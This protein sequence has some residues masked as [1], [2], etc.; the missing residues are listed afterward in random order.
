MY[1]SCIKSQVDNFVDLSDIDL[2]ILTL[3]SAGLS[4]CHM[5]IATSMY[6]A[7]I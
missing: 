1:L 2:Y 6:R 7:S 5:Y 3:C 4:H